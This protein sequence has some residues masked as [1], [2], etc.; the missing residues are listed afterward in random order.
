MPETTVTINIGPGKD[1]TLGTGKL[2][3]LANGQ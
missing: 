2:G 1:I 3:G